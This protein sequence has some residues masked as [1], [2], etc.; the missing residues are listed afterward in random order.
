MN[1]VTVE[2]QTFWR[3]RRVRVECSSMSEAMELV[4]LREWRTELRKVFDA[5]DDFVNCV[6]GLP[7]KG[8]RGILK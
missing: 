1:Q 5:S 3:G 7:F 4:A 2:F 8:L 6:A